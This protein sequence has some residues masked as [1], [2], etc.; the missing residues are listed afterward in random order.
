MTTITIQKPATI[1]V[2]RAAPIAAAI[3]FKFLDAIERFVTTR[4]EQ[5]AEASRI[6][7]ANV[8]RRYADQVRS[9][10]PRFAADLSA[11]ADR[12]ELS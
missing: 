9:F 3:A 12:H 8:V 11:A 7:E 4:R 6:A 2:P 10:D 5:R 1:R